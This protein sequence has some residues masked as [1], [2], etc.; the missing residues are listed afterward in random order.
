MLYRVL[1]HNGIAATWQMAL[2]GAARIEESV[3]GKAFN[4]G[5][6]MCWPLVVTPKIRFR[7]SG[8]FLDPE[9]VRSFKP[10]VM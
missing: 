6:V 9:G 3:S 7:S 8:S 2:S 5:L 1:I 10:G 4:F